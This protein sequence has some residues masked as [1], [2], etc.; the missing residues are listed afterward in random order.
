MALSSS[1]EWPVEDEADVAHAL[2]RA[3]IQQMMAT[4]G[5]GQGAKSQDNAEEHKGEATA[6]WGGSS[7]SNDSGKDAPLPRENR[8]LRHW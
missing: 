6:D 7:S 5:K 3:M 2:C 8:G 4:N 1:A